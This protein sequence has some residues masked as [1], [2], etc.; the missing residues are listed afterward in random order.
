[1]DNI[2]LGKNGSFACPVKVWSNYIYY[3]VWTIY[4]CMIN[5]VF[6]NILPI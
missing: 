5:K 4:A 6:L 1:M 2:R 3:S